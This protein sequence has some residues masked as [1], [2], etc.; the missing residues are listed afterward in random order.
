MA[1]SWVTGAAQRLGSPEGCLRSSATNN[2]QLGKYFLR[3]S[4]S[5]RG[6]T[7]LSAQRG[8]GRTVGA[9]RQVPVKDLLLALCE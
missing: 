1:P 2:D 7:F 5:G 6:N 8:R 9:Q 4:T 3:A